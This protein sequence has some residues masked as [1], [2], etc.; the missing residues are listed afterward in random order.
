MKPLLTF[1]IL[2]GTGVTVTAESPETDNTSGL[3]SEQFIYEE[4]AAQALK[5]EARDGYVTQLSDA[6][7]VRKPFYMAGKTN[8]VYDAL[9]V[10]NIG[11]EFYLGRNWSIG[12]DW[13]YSWWS[14]NSRHRYWR[15]YG[16]G[17]TLRRWFGRA[18]S[19]KPLTG[20]HIGVYGLAGTYDIEFG[21]TG[22]MGGKPGDNM[23]A[24]MS[25]G[26]G[27]EYGYSLPLTRRLNMD[28]TIG[29]GYLG[30]KYYKYKPYE[31]HYVWLETKNRHYF[32]PTKIEVSLVWLIGRGNANSN[33]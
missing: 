1:L 5:P 24:R 31:G 12:A 33:K 28:F 14:K 21:G 16:G 13:M 8:L 9:L 20:H 25:Y 26:G 2:L 23:F 17:I 3:S 18:A 30:G 10:P 27:I 11:L 4:L 29:L 19:E 7:D 15:I 6:D 22:Y 32:G